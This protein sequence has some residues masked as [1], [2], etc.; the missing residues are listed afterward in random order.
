M[1]I[2]L[3]SRKFV[4]VHPKLNEWS[5]ELHEKCEFLNTMKSLRGHISSPYN[6]HSKESKN[7]IHAIG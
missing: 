3:D 4:L 2:A 6:I 7:S 1:P 5:D